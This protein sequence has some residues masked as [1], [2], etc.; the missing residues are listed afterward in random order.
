MNLLSVLSGLDLLIV[1]VKP[2]FAFVN[3]WSWCGM[4]QPMVR[5][6]LQI[7]TRLPQTQLDGLNGSEPTEK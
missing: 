4:T 1:K 5:A 7:R 2:S 6:V 3:R